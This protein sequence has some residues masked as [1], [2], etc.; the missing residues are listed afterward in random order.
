[1]LLL[2]ISFDLITVFHTYREHNSAA[3]L[4][5]KEGLQ[6]NLEMWRIKETVDGFGRV[7]DN[8]TYNV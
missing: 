5:S 3:D 6:R 4:L 1:M 7:L 2:K 8:N